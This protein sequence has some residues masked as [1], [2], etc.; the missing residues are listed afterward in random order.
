MRNG[1]GGVWGVLF[2]DMC[3]RHYSLIKRL[4]ICEC[5]RGMLKGGFGLADKLVRLN[6]NIIETYKEWV[7]RN[8]CVFV[9]V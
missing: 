2:V 9:E 3:A 8:I 7:S 6:I 4:Y 5:G 1:S